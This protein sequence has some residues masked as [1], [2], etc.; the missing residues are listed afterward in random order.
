MPVA[1]YTVASAV[2]AIRSA[3]AHDNDQQVTD[4]MITGELDQEYRDLRRY[5]SQFA[6]SLYQ[7]TQLFTLV[8]PANTC[9]KPDD[10]ERLI[11][12]EVKFSQACWEPMAIRPTIAQSQGIA[13][14]VDGDYRLT[15][16][17][18][19]VDGYT[20]FD[21][22]EGANRILVNKVAAWVC[23]RFNDD[24]SWFDNKAEQLKVEL[25][26]DIIMRTGAHPQ[27]ALQHGA[28]GYG[29]RSFY[30]EGDHFVI[31]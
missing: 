2:T 5:L 17:A 24:P 7:K 10:F 6:P 28:M 11:R 16:V 31:V 21:L 14:P 3:T 22:P 27:C 20:A 26:R 1:Q 23:T 8:N 9:A 19:P 4:A 13:V 18:R 12:F 29:F 30:E 15:Y 25:R